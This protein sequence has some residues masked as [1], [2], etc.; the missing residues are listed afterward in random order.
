MSTVSVVEFLK[1]VP[2]YRVGERA[3]F[4]P[5]QA[6][7]YVRAGAARVVRE[8]APVVDPATTKAQLQ[9]EAELRAQAVRVQL[10]QI[11]DGKRA[12]ASACAE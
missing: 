7:A 9:A 10:S 8:R 12:P 11:G 4:S 2:P 6:E 5:A 3:G 1:T